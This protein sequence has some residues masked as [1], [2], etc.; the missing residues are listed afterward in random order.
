MNIVFG[1]YN[2]YKSLKTEKGGLY[3]FAK[4]LRKYNTDCKV[5]VICQK[6]HIFQ[7]LLD[8]CN[9]YN[10]FLYIDFTLKYGLMYYRFE[11]Y[12]DILLKYKEENINKILFTDMDDVIFQGDPFSI[13][14]TEQIYCAAEKNIITDYENWSSKVN[15]SWINQCSGIIRFFNENFE[16]QNVLCAGTI[17]GKYNGIMHYLKMYI[18][19]QI[20]KNGVNDQGLYNIIVYNYLDSAFRRILPYKISQILTLDNINFETLNITNN[21]IVNDNGEIYIILHQ[22]NDGCKNKGST[23]IHVN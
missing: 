2:G 21:K 15:I 9:E 22:I 23:T 19:T 17:L 16:N 13:E 18:D 20:K 7:E 12:H 10:I 4:S 11:I 8:F 1:V 6:E 14:F 3:Y 5:I